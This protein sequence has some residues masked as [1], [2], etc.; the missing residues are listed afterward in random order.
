MQEKS[1]KKGM[2]LLGIEGMGYS[3][4]VLI[5]YG[6]VIFHIFEEETRAFYELEKLWMDAKRVPLGKY[7]NE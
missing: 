6:D 1:A 3:H 2:K 7:N 5:D 4:W